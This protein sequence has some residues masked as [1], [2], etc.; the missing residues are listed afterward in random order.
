MLT[1]DQKDLLW[2]IGNQSWPTVANTRG[3]MSYQTARNHIGRFIRAGLVSVF[4]MPTVHHARTRYYQLT[5][6]GKARRQ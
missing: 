5:E 3:G 6:Q 4:T 2:R 1:H